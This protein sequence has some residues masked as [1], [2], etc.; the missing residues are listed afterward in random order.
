[1]EDLA[2]SEENG[3][4]VPDPNK[5]TDLLKEN[6]EIRILFCFPLKTGKEKNS[7]T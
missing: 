5:T 4:P 3:Y 1:M 7:R 2:G 6:L